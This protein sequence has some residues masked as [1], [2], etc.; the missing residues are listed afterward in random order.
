MS[1]S[2]T[3]IGSKQRV[4]FLHRRGHVSSGAKIMRCDQLSQICDRHLGDAYDFSVQSQ[5]PTRDGDMLRQSVQDLQGAIV[6][7]LKGVAK[8]FGPEGMEML[9]DKARGIC[10]DYVDATV[11]ESFSP[12][13]D[14]HIGAS[15]AGCAILENRLGKS[16]RV[17]GRPEVALLTHH[18][19]PRLDRY[20]MQEL[21][22]LRTVYMG[23]P[24]NLFLPEAAARQV[25]LLNY[26]DD[27]SI[28]D[29]FSALCCFNMHYCVRPPQRPALA[30]NMAK[31]FTKG[32]NAAALGANVMTTRDTA[33][34]EHYLGSDYPFLLDDA[35][36]AT[37]L[38]GLE[39]ARELYDTPAWKEASERMAHVR[40]LTSEAHIMGEMK[41]ILS[42]F[43]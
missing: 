42:R 14:V 12:F 11:A 30:R 16:G 1:K 10:I 27:S 5:S 17:V 26:F 3:G 21:H 41:A 19:D 23:H 29:V 40:E 9:H 33:D 15:H 31:P 18:A 43:A 22:S 7:L 6:I 24:Q 25:S 13:A 32:F 2:S 4:V 38:A 37:I 35:E 36:E 20:E 28:G 34:A 8:L 39:K